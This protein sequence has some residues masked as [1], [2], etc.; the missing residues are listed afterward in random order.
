MLSCCV[1]V[2]ESRDFADACISDVAC[3]FANP[4]DFAD[5]GRMCFIRTIASPIDECAFPTLQ[6]RDLLHILEASVFTPICFA[7]NFLNRDWL[8][9][10][11]PSNIGLAVGISV[12]SLHLDWM[13]A[14]CPQNTGL[15]VGISLT[16]V[17]KVHPLG[18]GG[19]RLRSGPAESADYG[20]WAP[21]HRAFRRR[22]RR[23]PRA[24]KTH[25][26]P[27]DIRGCGWPCQK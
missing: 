9:D 7:F 27:P 2:G 6:R 18:L 23:A 13:S 22:R 16:A 12:T 20:R 1:S 25:P 24:A 15:G 5:F 17:E 14:G 26:A 21:P 19:I 10:E 8:S 3:D 11:F 4:S